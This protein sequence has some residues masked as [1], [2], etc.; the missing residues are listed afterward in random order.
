MHQDRTIPT[1]YEGKDDGDSYN[2]DEVDRTIR[3]SSLIC[4]R[5]EKEIA[6]QQSSRSKFSEP[7]EQAS[8]RRRTYSCGW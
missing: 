7:D 6:A 1:N 8:E 3:E 2:Q 5:L 4:D